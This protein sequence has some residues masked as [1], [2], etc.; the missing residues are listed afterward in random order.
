MSPHPLTNFEI[1]K[2]H[3]NKL[4]FNG[5]LLRNNFS[6]INYRAYIINFV[7]YE[8]LGTH[9][10]ALYVIAENVTYF[11]SFGIEHILKEIRKFTRNK[12]IITNYL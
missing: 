3:Q 1:Q 9:W 11:D 5:V 6:K 4:N 8:S 12:N 2:Y 10:I 7:E